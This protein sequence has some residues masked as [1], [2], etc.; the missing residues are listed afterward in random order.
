MLYTTLLFC[1]MTH[2]KAKYITKYGGKTQVKY[3][4]YYNTIETGYRHNKTKNW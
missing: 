4:L 2:A 3:S 1:M